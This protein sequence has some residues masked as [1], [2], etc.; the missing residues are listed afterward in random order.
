M[1]R[2]LPPL[3]VRTAVLPFLLAL[4]AAA[5]TRAQDALPRG[6]EASLAPASTADLSAV[7]RRT[8]GLTADADAA[9]YAQGRAA[10]VALRPAEA[11]AAFSR[12]AARGHAAG[13]Y[14]IETAWLWEALVTEE[15]A[16]VE[17]FHAVNDSL[18]RVADRLPDSPHAEWLRAS[19]ALH[20][21]VALGREERYSRAGLAFRDACRRFRSLTR[22]SG[23]SPDAHL[24]Q[25]VCE[26]AVGSA[27]RKYRW[28]IRLAGLSGS[29]AGGLDHLATAAAGG[30]AEAMEATAVRAFV[31]ESL[32][33]SRAGARE[34]LRTMSEAQPNSPVLAFLAGYQLLSDRRAADAEAAF[35]R[36][37]A[38]QRVPGT[39]ALPTIPAHLGIAVFR[40]D[41]FAEAAPLIEQFVTR[42]SGR[43]F[44]AQATL[45][46]GLA[47][48]MNGERAAAE[49]HYRRVRATRDY[50]TDLA[51]AREAQR[52][53]REPLTAHG[54][55]L[56]MG[57]TAYDSGRYRVAIERL[58]PV[59]ADAAAPAA[60]RAE[61][62]YR[63][64]R[65]HHALREH[66][67]AMRHY[68][69]AIA[70]PGD[71]LAR[72]GPWSQFHLGEVLEATGDRDGARAAYQAVLADEREF[73]HSK[74]LEGR[75]R[76]AL[77]RL[78]R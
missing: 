37:L 23:A 15:R 34:A 46:A 42:P 14:G 17:R 63:T 26:V 20:R 39:L 11:R 38:A 65:A 51:A 62:A 67:A 31:D 13:G 12:L 73:D 1:L 72:W 52:R 56:V 64:G 55:A 35:R 28:I 25:G 10:L 50:D 74:A 66:E 19:V 59:L 45:V 57:L 6:A 69:M 47:R 70:A 78:G 49:A 7:A 24:G 40:Q 54:R 3:P 21:A 18:G 68:R 60:E 16:A 76:A 36:A 77:D 5:P 27:P 41:R 71:P 43:S 2:P 33:G 29:V 8:L 32:N 9:L 4:V 44:V 75:A 61:A 22:A 58:A 53:L 30:G 48:E